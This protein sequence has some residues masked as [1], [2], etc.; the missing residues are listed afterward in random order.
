MLHFILSLLAPGEKIPRDAT[1]FSL[2][3][4]GLSWGWAFFAFVGLVALTVWS[5]RKFAPTLGY[6][7]RP[8]L[9]ILRSILLALLLFLLV[10]PVL[11][12]TV[13]ETV[14]RPLLVLLDTTQS[15]GL[16]DHRGHPEDIVRA[17][18]AK[19]L[20]D[21]AGGL[22]QTVSSDAQNSV[23][24][25]SRRDLLEAL[26]A[27]PK[28]NLWPRLNEHANLVFYGFGRKIG[29]LGELA[30]PK[31]GKLTPEES[32]SF[33]HALKYDDNLTAIGDSLRELLDEER[34]QPN[35]G[36]LL[37]TDGANNTGSSP[38]E[39]AEIAKE[40]EV[41]LFIYGVGVTSPQDIMVAGLDAPQVAN[42]KEKLTVTAH[43]RAQ[44]MLGRKGTIQLKA[45]GKIVDEEPIEFRADGEQEVQLSYIPDVMGEADLEAYVP[46]LP[47]E[48]VKDNN[49][50]KATVRIA[51]NKIKVLVVEEQ[52]NWDFQ[53]LIQML[54]RDRRIKLKV[55]LIKGDPE[56]T[57]DPN[58]PFIDK[59]PDDKET[60]SSNDLVVIGDVDPADLGPARMKILSDWVSNLGGGIIFQAG[61]QSDPNAYRGTPLEPML[62]IETQG[63]TADR[64]DNPV[65]LS[66]T[67]A[68]EDSILTISQDPQ[69]N[70]ALWGGFPG[71]HWTAWV[72]KARPGARV[73][74]TDPTAS[75]STEQGPMPVIAQQDYGRGQ[76]LYVGFRETYRWRSH[77]G[78][79]FY[80]QIWGQMI[81][82]LTSAHVIG[83]SAMTQLQTDKPSYFTGD[84]V[85]ISGRLFQ[86]GMVPMT[87]AEVP[88][89]LIF[90]PDPTANQPAPIQQTKELR[91]ESVPDQAGEYRV[92][93]TASDAGSYSYSTA[94][95]PKVI[96][97]WKV[98]QPHVELSDIAMNEKLL[99]GMA[100][101]AGGHF[102][103]EEDLNGLPA[104]M[105]SQSSGTITFK[106]IPLAFAPALLAL[107][108]I[109]ACLE[110]LWRRKL[111]LK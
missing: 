45:N 53:Y 33:F 16:V 95:D 79:S 48:A 9:I 60:L 56:S 30:P 84:K 68:G 55:D 50:A 111:E 107:I 19:G 5:Y 42:V 98:L 6:F 23:Q 46:P 8:G 38:L 93:T 91:L 3:H 62:P 37:I 63:K 28:L 52:P 82:A 89:I 97:K 87:D 43:I 85:R 31:G 13:D 4:E 27:N 54:Q 74:L 34:G 26:A 80:T 105:T 81:Q 29:E 109:V 104:L 2:E 18:I 110:W 39:A 67:P 49:S 21:P 70:L 83:A 47:E 24:A 72:G 92:E 22:K 64:Y 96:L 94:R 78:E 101:A 32:A 71:V 106:R 14:R 7:T 77:Q 65:K 61:P 11:L 66:L 57:T 76:S 25:L 35:S 86:S 103:R 1:Q 41:P 44:S 99:R 36:V 88:G 90:T 102:L 12:I 69:K 40:D 10:R 20:V 58:S 59:L 17:A 51:D 108:I 75:R 73:L 100:A 15:M